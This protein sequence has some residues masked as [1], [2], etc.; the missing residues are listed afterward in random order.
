MVGRR[1]GCRVFDHIRLWLDDRESV[2]HVSAGHT[3]CIPDK[4]EISNV[5]LLAGTWNVTCRG[6]VTY[7]PLPVE[8]RP[9]IA[10]LL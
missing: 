5:I 7:V 4:N 10:V 3:G 1:L 2:K 9:R 6:K 8:N